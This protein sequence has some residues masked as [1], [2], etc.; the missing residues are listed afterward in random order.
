M[1]LLRMAETRVM[2]EFKITEL[3]EKVAAKDDELKSM[4]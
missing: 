1:A 4:A 3:E 2:T